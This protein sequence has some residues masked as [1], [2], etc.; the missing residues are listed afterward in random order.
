MSEIMEKVVAETERVVG[1]R[2]D[3]CWTQRRNL[4]P[5][6]KSMPPQ[7]RLAELSRRRDAEKAADP[8]HHF[9]SGHS[10]WGNDSVESWESCDACSPACYLQLVA[11][12]VE[13]LEQYPSAT[14]DDM[15]IKFAAAL[16]RH[17]GA[18]S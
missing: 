3:A 6:S 10:D 18:T 12:E 15:P 17:I 8:W 13:R 9:Q 16:L 4:P 11:Q 14:I 1:H 5:I 2:C 7:E